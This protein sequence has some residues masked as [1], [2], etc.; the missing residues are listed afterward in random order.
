[1]LALA[2]S[3]GSSRT[4]WSLFQ[5]KKSSRDLSHFAGRRL[6]LTIAYSHAQKIFQELLT[7]ERKLAAHGS[8]KPY[9]QVLIYDG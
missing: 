5:V 2:L 3:E 4:F 8:S 9:A 1:M 6:S 7:G